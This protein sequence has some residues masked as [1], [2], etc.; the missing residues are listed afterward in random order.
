MEFAALNG[1]DK[2]EFF[3]LG[4]F[5]RLNEIRL[6][7]CRKSKFRIVSIVDCLKNE[8]HIST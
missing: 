1:H 7:N 4:L 6:R 5:F 3:W 2:R 8:M